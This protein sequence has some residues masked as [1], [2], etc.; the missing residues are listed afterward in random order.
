MRNKLERSVHG[1]QTKRANSQNLA[2][3]IIYIQLITSLYLRSGDTI[4]SSIVD[5]LHFEISLHSLFLDT[6]VDGFPL[7]RFMFNEYS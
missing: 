1:T 6:D 2:V 7:V 3:A 5:F 4:I